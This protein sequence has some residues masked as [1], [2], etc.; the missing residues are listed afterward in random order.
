MFKGEQVLVTGGSGLIGR[1]LIEL[2]LKEGA[3][4]R[5]SVGSRPLPEKIREHTEVLHVDLSDPEVCKKIT[6]DVRYVFHLAAFVG[7]VKQNTEHPAAMMTNNLV[8]NSNVIKASQ[9][10]G[11]ERYAFVSCG[12][13][14]PDIDGIINEEMAWSGPPAAGAIHFGW[15]KRVGELEAQAYQQEFGMNVSIIRPSNAYGPGD[16]YDKYRSHA[17][18]ALIMKAVERLKPFKIWGSGESKRDFIYAGDVARGIMLAMEKYSTG[19]PVNISTGKPSSINELAEKILRLSG[20]NDAEILHESPNLTGSSSKVL[21]PQKAIQKMN[22]KPEVDLE[23][24][25]RQTIES[26]VLGKG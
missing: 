17:V 22:F 12:C 1:H 4:V 20:Y 8:L 24:G 7:G 9:Q 15:T 2:L 21:N 6:K 23:E 26:Y 10:A 5:T 13:V 14:Y 25:L 16:L 3:T 18:P 19:D 11:V